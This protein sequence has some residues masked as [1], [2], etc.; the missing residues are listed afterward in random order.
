MYVIFLE[1]SD[2]YRLCLSVSQE[3]ATSSISLLSKSD[4][5]DLVLYLVFSAILIANTNGS[6]FICERSCQFFSEEFPLFTPHQVLKWG[7]T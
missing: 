7:I 5:K 4:T 2:M 3:R 1:E 6:S